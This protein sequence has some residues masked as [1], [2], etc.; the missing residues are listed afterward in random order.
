MRRA[1]HYLLDDE[2]KISSDMFARAFAGFPS[3]EGFLAAFNGAPA[4]NLR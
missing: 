1:A 4:A 2:P 3:D